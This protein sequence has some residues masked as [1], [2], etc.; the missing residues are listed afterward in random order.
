[1]PVSASQGYHLILIDGHNSSGSPRGQ[2][3]AFPISYIEFPDVG[4]KVNLHDD[5]T[6]VHTAYPLF[7]VYNEDGNTAEAS[8]SLIHELNDVLDTLRKKQ[9]PT[10]FTLLKVVNPSKDGTLDT[11]KYEPAQTIELDKATIHLVS[12]TDNTYQVQADAAILGDGDKA[13][14]KTNI[15]YK[16]K[17]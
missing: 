1:M 5:S 16:D 6:F 8:A 9:A 17:I 4:T 3:G 13:T 11:T 7:T 10:K 2:K 12:G 15:D 14:N